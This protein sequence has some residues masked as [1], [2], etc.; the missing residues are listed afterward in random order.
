MILKTLPQRPG[1]GV[2]TSKVLVHLGGWICGAALLYWVASQAGPRTGTAIVH[3]TEPDVAVSVGSQMFRVDASIHEPL[4]CDLPAGEHRLK[5]MRGTTVLY[6]ETFSIVG[7]EEHVLTTWRAPT[8]SARGAENRTPGQ[9]EPI[10]P[11]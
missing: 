11:E 8:E 6:D 2:L 4:V 7:G 10:S 9:P 1:S 3:V 5:M